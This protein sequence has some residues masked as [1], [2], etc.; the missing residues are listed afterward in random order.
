LSSLPS[1]SVNPSAVLPSAASALPVAAVEPAKVSGEQAKGESDRL[2]DAG[3]EF[4]ASA[5]VPVVGFVAPT[6]SG[7]G[8]FSAAAERGP[9]GAPRP[10]APAASW[11]QSLRDRKHHA[12]LLAQNYYW[13]FVTHIL[14][15]WPSYSKNWKDA[16][17]KPAPAVTDPRGFFI[18]MRLAGTSG[19][20]YVLGAAPRD[21]AGAITE[22]RAAFAR[23]FDGPGI[24][25]REREA[26]DRFMARAL[27]YNAE[28]RA[29]TNMRKNVREALLK[30][31]TMKAGDIAPYFDSLM[32]DEAA[33]ETWNFQN[34]G[35]QKRVL[36]A[37]R[38]TLL[39]VLDREDASAPDRVVGAIVLG[40][41][42]SGSAG[43]NSDFDVELVSLGGKSGRRDAFTDKLVA[44][45]KARGLHATNPVTVHAYPSPP[46]R[47]AVDRVHSGDYFVVS[48][49]A[50]LVAALSRA[51]G[52]A[53][54]FSMVR[55]LT[56]RGRVNRAVQKGIILAATYWADAKARF[57]A[58]PSGH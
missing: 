17:A 7:L 1:F 49:D 43:P 55:V 19:R 13:C 52:E 6:A 45:W 10:A 9:A 8:R 5:S 3:R 11:L 40:S 57:G 34:K 27:D 39:G 36:D 44:A 23:W 21:D 12:V 14:S 46:S 2:F 4:S 47:G 50:E 29:P 33:R 28:R 54:K 26:L 16:A 35:A 18:A 42:A 15:V 24:G 51:E 22:F 38:E 41:F 25:S 58:A 20:F 53:P 32:K 37:F 56:P 31:S 48:R 30:A